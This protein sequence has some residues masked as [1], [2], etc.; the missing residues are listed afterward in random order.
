MKFGNSFLI[1]T[2]NYGFNRIG[3]IENLYKI[4]AKCME[5]I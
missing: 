5:L 2:F 3:I 4:K 1:L